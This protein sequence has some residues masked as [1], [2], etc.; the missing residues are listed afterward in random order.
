M[1]RYVELSRVLAGALLLA[2]AAGPVLHEGVEAVEFGRGL[3]TTERRQE[4]PL[5]GLGEL[6]PGGED[7]GIAVSFHAKQ[8]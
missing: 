3:R 6:H 4:A 1:W 8:E 7:R 5:S 2:R